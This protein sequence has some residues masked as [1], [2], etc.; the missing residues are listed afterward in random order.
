M[1][2]LPVFASV[3]LLGAAASC[4]LLTDLDG[5]AED[6]DTDA[7][8]EVAAEA[9]AARPTD[10]GAGEDAAPPGDAAAIDAGFCSW[11]SPA[12]DFCEDFDTPPLSGAWRLRVDDGG[13]L[14]VDDQISSSAPSS[15]RAIMVPP[16]GEEACRSAYGD[17]KLAV[18]YDA[19]V[20]VEADVR[21]GDGEGG[22]YPH[23]DV[24]VNRTILASGAGAGA[25][26]YFFLVR[27]GQAKLVVQPSTDGGSVTIVTL[28]EALARD[29]WTRV[30]LE[31]GDADV[32]GE[33][34]V[35]VWFDDV[36]VLDAAPLPADCAHGRVTS[37]TPGLFCV[38]SGVP[39]PAVLH[40][41]NVVV[42]AD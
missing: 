18:A 17:H 25:C 19:L 27:P 36:R 1:A 22:G 30:A 2:R 12:P 5:L 11:L 6:G 4:T 24:A 13:A 31:I 41:D 10:G 40:V 32:P 16:T 15:L 7:G 28:R 20:R 37:V 42:R 34:H 21:L 3:V 38:S 26:Q 39:D 29:G 9:D 14:G 23:E 8:V 33:A 35:S